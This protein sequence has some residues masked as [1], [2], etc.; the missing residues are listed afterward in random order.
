MFLYRFA[1]GLAGLAILLVTSVLGLGNQFVA[2][3]TIVAAIL[4]AV[5]GYMLAR[6]FDNLEQQV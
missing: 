2:V 5:S 3:L 1:R 6:E 4:W